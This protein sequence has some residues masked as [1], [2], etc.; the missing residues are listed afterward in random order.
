MVAATRKEGLVWEICDSLINNRKTPTIKLVGDLLEKNGHRR[1]SNRD[2]SMY[3]R[4]WREYNSAEGQRSIEG[5]ELPDPL[6]RALF[7]LRDEV[8]QEAKTKI[9]EIEQTS[10]DKEK[11]LLDKLSL[12]QQAREALQEDFIQAQAKLEDLTSSLTEKEQQY[13]ELSQALQVAGNSLQNLEDKLFAQQDRFTQELERKQKN[14]SEL[15]VQQQKQQEA[16][17]QQ[18]A[19]FISTKDKIVAEKISLVEAKVGLEH[20]LVHI[21][22]QNTELQ[23][24]LDLAVEKNLSLLQQILTM[25]Q[26]SFGAKQKLQTAINAT[27]LLQQTMLKQLA[28]LEERQI[29][30][31]QELSSRH[32]QSQAEQKHQQQLQQK[33]ESFSEIILSVERNF[34]ALKKEHK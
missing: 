3:M 8:Q 32:K 27:E 6:Q 33:L 15:L 25:Q 19:E 20:K 18:L 11:E 13:V 1:G 24:A 23:T 26:E 16:W 5:V 10:K 2:L 12:E 30:L 28:K 34:K 14:Y 22:Q 17:Q 29:E 7:S 9:E 4:S 31:A 21:K